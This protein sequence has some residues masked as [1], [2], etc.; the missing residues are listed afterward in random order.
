VVDFQRGDG[1]PSSLRS[2]LAGQLCPL[3]DARDE[4]LEIADALGA[5]PSDVLLEE[6]ATERAVRSM[7]PRAAGIIAFATHALVTGNGIGSLAEPA[8]IM[9]LPDVP[10]E[11][12]D[13]G[14]LLASEI[15]QLRIEADWVILSACNTAAPAGQAGA[16]GLSGLAKAFFTAGTRSL[17]VSHWWVNSKAAVRLTTGAVHALKSK[18]RPTA[19]Q[20]L[21][22]AMRKMAIEPAEPEWAHP[23]L[24]APFVVV[25]AAD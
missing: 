15:A 7:L 6:Q 17:L 5:K 18:A 21:Q 25:G 13:N 3:E 22:Q 8:L 2:L 14:V 11:D 24:W 12:D 1:I 23:V 4:L 10:L 19:A 20:A 9:H 16:E